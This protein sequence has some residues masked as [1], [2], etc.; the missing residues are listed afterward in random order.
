[1]SSRRSTRSTTTVAINGDGI[2]RARDEGRIVIAP[3][4]SRR[5]R[6]ASYVLSLGRRFRRWR[7]RREPI[8]L[9]SPHAARNHLAAPTEVDTITLESGEFVLGCTLEAIGVAP[10]MTG[11]LS[12]LSHVARFGLDIHGG[13]SLVNPC[14]GLNAPTP[15]TLEIYNRNASPIVLHSTIPFAHLRFETLSDQDKERAKRSIYEGRDPL[16]EPLLFEEWSGN[17]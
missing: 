6:S 15:L 16:V 17:R 11:H 13:A 7:T 14:F 9:W 4:D 10:E 1:M 3:F 8:V 5:V 2:V 12:P